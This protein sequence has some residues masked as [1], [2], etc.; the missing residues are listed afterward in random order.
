MAVPGQDERDWAF[1][2]AYGLPIVRTVQPPDG[3]QGQAY[4]GEGPAVNSANAGTGDW[5]ST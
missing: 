5:G 3:W 4:V 2:E 1:A